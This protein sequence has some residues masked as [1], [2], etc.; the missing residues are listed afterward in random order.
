MKFTTQAKAAI[1][2]VL[3]AILVAA[4]L[5]AAIYLTLRP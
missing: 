5:G 2:S 3:G 1:P 4:I